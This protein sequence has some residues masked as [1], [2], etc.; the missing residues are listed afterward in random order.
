MNLSSTE[1]E[2]FIRIE[3]TL[4]KRFFGY[5]ERSHRDE[6]IAATLIKPTYQVYN[7]IQQRFYVSSLENKINK[8]IS[9]FILNNVNR[10]YINKT[11]RPSYSHRSLIPA[12]MSKL[13]ITI[14]DHP[15]IE[16]KWAQ[17][18]A[19][20]SA[21]NEENS[22]TKS[23]KRIRHCLE[24]PCQV[25]RYYIEHKTYLDFTKKNKK[26]FNPYSYKKRRSS[27]FI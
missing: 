19:E 10:D 25:N 5:Y 16:I 2:A 12:I 11:K 27:T 17:F 13:E 3:H 20:L 4:I 7:E 26:S 14:G 18:I 1:I 9:D 21:T 24:N 8:T 23:A 15:T 22:H 6:F